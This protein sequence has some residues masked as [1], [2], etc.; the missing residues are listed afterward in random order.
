MNEKRFRRSS[1][2][3]PKVILKRRMIDPNGPE[4]VQ[5]SEMLPHHRKNSLINVNADGWIDVIWLDVEGNKPTS[6]KPLLIA[7]ICI[8]ILA[9]AYILLGGAL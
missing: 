5:I 1:K 2:T 4:D 3:P 6:G 8:I 7:G 9:C